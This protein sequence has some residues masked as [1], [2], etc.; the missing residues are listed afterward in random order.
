MP[1]LGGRR[2][3]ASAGR[4]LQAAGVLKSMASGSPQAL[5]YR[6][7]IKRRH[8]DLVGVAPAFTVSGGPGAVM[9]TGRRSR[10]QKLSPDPPLW[11]V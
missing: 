2:D 1:G 9:A 11:L 10:A 7:N 6:L 4:Q 3:C 5:N 8:A